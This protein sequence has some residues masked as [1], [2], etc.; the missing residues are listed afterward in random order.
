MACE[1]TASPR[2]K[3]ETKVV[4]R[5]YPVWLVVGSVFHGDKDF[6]RRIYTLVQGV[7]ARRGRAVRLV[8]IARDNDSVI[9]I[10][11]KEER[12]DIVRK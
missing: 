5:G 6:V 12:W 11:G 7:R 1:K 8:L 2:C 9:V 3:L 10:R 4:L